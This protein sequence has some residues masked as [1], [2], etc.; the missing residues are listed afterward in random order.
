MMKNLW[1][2]PMAAMLAILAGCGGS[3]GDD[4]VGQFPPEHDDVEVV[5]PTSPT[6]STGSTTT[7]TTLP[8]TP[9]TTSTAPVTSTTPS[10]PPT[11]STTPLACAGQPAFCDPVVARQLRADMVNKFN[12]FIDHNPEPGWFYLPDDPTQMTAADR[13]KFMDPTV[14]PV[15]FQVRDDYPKETM[16]VMRRAMNFMRYAVHT[17]AFAHILKEK[18]LIDRGQI[19]DYRE[20]LLAVR[21]M[22]QT[23]TIRLNT[24]ANVSTGAWYAVVGG[25]VV[26]GVRVPPGGAIPANFD[27]LFGIGGRTDLG[28]TTS[29]NYVGAPSY[30]YAIPKGADGQIDPAR[31]GSFNGLGNWTMG[32]SRQW[33]SPGI[34]YLTIQLLSHEMLHVVGYTHSDSTNRAALA[35]WPKNANGNAEL[36]GVGWKDVNYGVG[37]LLTT[38]FAHY[39]YSSDIDFE[40]KYGLRSFN[41]TVLASLHRRVYGRDDATQKDALGRNKGW[42]ITTQDIFFPMDYY[43]TPY[44]SAASTLVIRTDPTARQF[45]PLLGQHTLTEINDI[46]ANRSPGETVPHAEVQRTRLQP[47]YQ[48]A[49]GNPA[50]QTPWDLYN[51]FRD[52]VTG[53]DDREY[54]DWECTAS[55]TEC[56]GRPKTDS[57][58]KPDHGGKPFYFRTDAVWRY[59][60]PKNRGS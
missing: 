57:A 34:D 56:Y 33:F 19:A 38:L 6:P 31:T 16:E 3:G 29:W 21:K 12:D 44:V 11:T 1:T 4:G 59:T 43:G 35:G 54:F 24:D 13:A 20:V 17:K 26:S 46:L 48:L 53:K 55:Q 2:L 23:F 42:Y 27:P 60:S 18:V 39:M 45:H 36:D 40:A 50:A 49:P 22:N 58:K 47:A 14:W 37:Q 10:T 32:P 51:K 15:E 30:D 8:T 28:V 9:P 41:K 25:G 5:I 7:T 52:A